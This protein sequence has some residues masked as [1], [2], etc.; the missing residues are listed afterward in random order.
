[1][2]VSLPQGKNPFHAVLASRTYIVPAVD[3]PDSIGHGGS[4]RR[5][6]CA[7]VCGAE[8]GIIQYDPEK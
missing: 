1:M 7:I 2:K 6:L 3:A 5:R 8:I 4:I